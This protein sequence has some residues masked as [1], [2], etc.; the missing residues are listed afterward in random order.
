MKREDEDRNIRCAFA[1]AS[2]CTLTGLRVS[3]VPALPQSPPQSS[4][5][6]HA[7]CPEAHVILCQDL[8]N[9]RTPASRPFPI[10]H[11]EA[12]AWVLSGC[13]R[14]SPLGG[15]GGG[16]R[17]DPALHLPLGNG[18]LEG[19]DL[20]RVTQSLCTP[21]CLLG[22]FWPPAGGEPLLRSHQGTVCLGW[23]RAPWAAQP[24]TAHPGCSR[25]RGT[26]RDETQERPPQGRGG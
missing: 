9:P 11:H 17:S 16:C 20:P 4:E 13:R 3:E 8:K 21:L 15:G 6:F 12:S 18:G 1:A 10:S 22:S 19:S 23:P 14:R 5:C 26:F 24:L 7:G 2:V 25:P